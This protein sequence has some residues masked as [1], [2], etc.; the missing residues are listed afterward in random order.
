M[1]YF[2]IVISVSFGIRLGWRINYCRE[3][4]F[5]WFYIFYIIK[6]YLLLYLVCVS[7][8]HQAILFFLI[9]QLTI[10]TIHYLAVLFDIGRLNMDD[11]L[12]STQTLTENVE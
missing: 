11:I 6:I 7:T 4:L 8:T 1:K 3:F 9:F 12:V 10:N 2:K 5:A